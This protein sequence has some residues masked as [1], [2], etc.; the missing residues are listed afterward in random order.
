MLYGSQKRFD[1]NGDG[2]LKGAEWQRWYQYAYG[3]EIEAKEKR[4]RANAAA[5]QKRAQIAADFADHV[6][7]LINWIYRD[8]AH[9]EGE[10]EDQAI[11]TMHLA[12]Y[13]ISAAL[14]TQRIDKSMR[15]LLRAFWNE[16]QPTLDESVYQALCA[17]QVLFAEIGEI[18]EKRLGSFWKGLLDELPQERRVGKDDDLQELLDDTNRLY[19][20]FR[21]DSAPGIDFAKEIE[22]YWTAIRLPEETEEP[23]E[24]D[25]GE[26][27]EEESE[28]WTECYEKEAPA[29]GA[30]GGGYY[31]FCKV[32]FKE[33]GTSYS[34]LTGGISLKARD[35]VMVPVGRYDAEKLAR[36]ADVFVC[37]AQDAPYPPEKTKFVL[38]KSEQTAFPEK[39]A[40][41]DE[42]AKVE[43]PHV[44]MQPISKELPAKQPAPKETA[45]CEA[46]AA[47]EPAVFTLPPLP[48]RE[49][50]KKPKRRI[51]WGWLAAAALAAFVIFEVPPLERI[52]ETNRQQIAAQQ[53]A[54]Q[55][56][57]E[58]EERRAE[59]AR[60]E[61]EAAAQR[62]REERE[63]AIQTQKDAGLPY[64]GMSES[65]IDSTRT[66]GTHGTAK[67]EQHYEHDWRGNVKTVVSVTYTWYT[68]NRKAIF[69]ATCEDEKVVETQALGGSS[70]W[71]G[72]KLLVAV[73]KPESLP[74]Q[75]FDSG[76]SSSGKD[77]SLGHGSTGLRDEYDNPEDLYED[78]PDD[79]EDEDEAW[80]EWEND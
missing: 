61:E 76:S 72:N 25:E 59:Q 52:A 20:Y 24:D 48:E 53:A 26:E 66:L 71:D 33:N 2:K 58:R 27:P 12:L 73:V 50:P 37:S 11:R 28:P 19:N 62:R 13:V 60:L 35:F 64:V 30:A 43:K 41:Q 3:N 36:V 38:R 63:A 79:Y 34:Y 22:P 8:L 18:S 29:E 16:F 5:E 77:S 55:E 44:T 68:E 17:K 49:E 31:Q 39:K 42:P 45:S 1:K 75:T 57:R 10:R 56:K 67:K 65:S 32:Q 47:T 6:S 7:D 80:D 51:P 70:C 78:N 21:D 9:L 69:T 15:Y 14:Q 4:R 40:L 23:E 46:R 74:L 54:E